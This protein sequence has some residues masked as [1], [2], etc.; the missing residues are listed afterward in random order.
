MRMR[1]HSPEQEGFV[2]RD[3]VRIFYEVFGTGDPAVLL[4]PTWSIV[5]SRI[6]KM[7]VPFE[8]LVYVN[9]TGKPIARLD[10]DLLRTITDGKYMGLIHATLEEVL[11]EA[12]E[13]IVEVRFGR[14]L[15]AIE[16]G[17][18]AVVVT[19]NDGTTESFDLLIGA[20]GQVLSP[21][22]HGRKS[23]PSIGSRSNSCTAIVGPPNVVETEG[24]SSEYTM[25]TLFNTAVAAHFAPGRDICQPTPNKSSQVFQR[26]S[27]Y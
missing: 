4:L 3:G 18:D 7:Q 26:T 25:V 6:W 23:T 5:H 13:G 10:A 16:S 2:E 17:P 22:S 19:F 15:V 20:D 27:S 24:V 14:W 12:L 9:T 11:Y 8:A 1:A 21:N